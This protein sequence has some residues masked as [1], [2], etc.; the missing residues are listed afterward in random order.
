LDSATDRAPKVLLV[1]GIA[2]EQELESFSMTLTTAQLM[3][4]ERPRVEVGNLRV[5]RRDGA[6]DITAGSFVVNI[7]FEWVEQLKGF[8]AAS[9]SSSEGGV[10]TPSVPAPTD[11]KPFCAN[12]T[13]SNV[14]ISFAFKGINARHSGNLALPLAKIAVGYTPGWTADLSD[15]EVSVDNRL[16][17]RTT[18]ALQHRDALL[19]AEFE[20]FDLNIQ[21]L[22][23]RFAMDAMSYYRLFFPS[24][25][26]PEVLTEFHKTWDQIVEVRD[27]HVL[28]SEGARLLYRLQITNFLIQMCPFETRATGDRLVIDEHTTGDDFAPLIDAP[29][30]LADIYT[31][32]KVISWS[33]KGRIYLKLAEINWLYRFFVYPVGEQAEM[34]K[35][36][37]GIVTES[38]FQV[39][40]PDL[41]MDLLPPNDDFGVCRTDQLSFLSHFVNGA[42]TTT[43][44]FAATN[45]TTG[46]MGVFSKL[47]KWD[48]FQ[49]ILHSGTLSMKWIGCEMGFQYEFFMSVYR[50]LMDLITVQ[51]GDPNGPWRVSPYF[52]SIEFDKLNAT[53]IPRQMDSL[54]RGMCFLFDGFTV[55]TEGDPKIMHI[56]SPKLEV[57]SPSKQ[58]VMLFE[59]M[60]IPFEYG[61][62]D[63]A[64]IPDPDPAY[65]YVKKFITP[66]H[67]DRLFYAYARK[68]TAAYLD[69]FKSF[70]SQE[71]PVISDSPFVV[72]YDTIIDVGI[73]EIE[74]NDLDYICLCVLKDMHYRIYEQHDLTVRSIFVENHGIPFI[75]SGEANP[76]LVFSKTAAGMTTTITNLTVIFDYETV[77]RFI[78]AVWISPLLVFQIR[79]PPPDYEPDP[80]WETVYIIESSQWVFPVTPDIAG[81]RLLFSFDKFTC[82]LKL[83]QRLY[84][85]LNGR[86][87]WNNIPISCITMEQ[88]RYSEMVKGP[89]QGVDVFLGPL[90]VSLGS[91]DIALLSLIPEG[92]SSMSR[93]L[94]WESGPPTGEPITHTVYSANVRKISFALTR[95][96]CW[97]APEMTLL[98]ISLSQWQCMIDT[99]QS[100]N[101]PIALAF[102]SLVYMNQMT[103]LP[104]D[105]L[106]P[107]IVHVNLFFSEQGMKCRI[108][109][110]GEFNINI[111]FQALRH[112]MRF[113]GDVG[114]RMAKKAVD[115]PV[116]P[117]LAIVNETGLPA[118]FSL[119]NRQEDVP[120]MESWVTG[121]VLSSI[122]RDMPFYFRTSATS[123]QSVLLSNLE[124]P[125]FITDSIAVRLKRTTLGHGLVF[126]SLLKFR[127]RLDY[128]VFLVSATERK[129]LQII[130]RIPARSKAPFPWRERAD[131]KF[132]FVD[133]IAV[134]SPGKLSRTIK[135]FQIKMF[136][137]R[138]G[139][140]PC[141]GEDACENL[142]L[143][144]K[145]SQASYVL[146]L[147]IEPLIVAINRLP[148]PMG[149]T[150]SGRTHGLPVNEPVG[151]RRVKAAGTFRAH[152][153]LQGWTYGTT[154]VSISTE[155]EATS[156]LV[157][158][159]ELTIACDAVRKDEFSQI[160]LIFYAPVILFN[161]SSQVFYVYTGPKDR[162]CEFVP[163]LSGADQNNDGILLLGKRSYFS[164]TPSLPIQLLVPADPNSTVPN[165]NELYSFS[166]WI[167]CVSLDTHKPFLI[168]HP[169]MR[170]TFVPLHYTI[171]S[172]QPYARSI[173]VTV[174]SQYSVT[175][176]LGYP[177]TIQP[178]R[179]KYKG[180]AI[181]LQVRVLPNQ[182]AR[183]L[184]ASA[185]MCFGFWSD[186]SPH[187]V[188]LE[189]VQ[190]VRRTFLVKTVTDEPAFI[191]YCLEERGLDIAVTFKRANF[192][193]P[194]MICNVFDVD[195]QYSQ[196]PSPYRVLVPARSTRI[197]GWE[198]PAAVTFITVHI[199]GGEIRICADLTKEKTQQVGDQTVHVFFRTMGRFQLVFISP[200]P[201]EAAPET[202]FSLKLV[203]PNI[204]VALIDDKVREFLLFSM[205]H[206]GA[207]FWRNASLSALSVFVHAV[208]LDDLHPQ[209]YYRVPMIGDPCGNCHFVEFRCSMYSNTALFT[210]FRDISFR[211]QQLLFF[212]DIRFLSDL[213]NFVHPHLS[214]T[215]EI[216]PPD[217]S[218]S[219]STLANLP[220][221]VDALIIYPASILISSRTS[222]GRPNSSPLFYS[223]MRFVPNITGFELK[224]PEKIARD[225]TSINA[226][227]LQKEI[228]DGY[229]SA[230]RDQLW[231]VI[232]NIDLLGRKSMTNTAVKQELAAGVEDAGLTAM[233]RR[234][235]R[236]MPRRQILRFDHLLSIWQSLIQGDRNSKHSY[237]GET[238]ELWVRHKQS[239]RAFCF[240]QRYCFEIL[241]Q[242]AG[243]SLQLG[244]IEKLKFAAKVEQCVQESTNNEPPILEV[245]IAGR[246]PK[247]DLRIICPDFLTAE[248]VKSYIESRYRALNFGS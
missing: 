213:L 178:L 135:T 167:E 146:T 102:T 221:S 92:F 131:K 177:I 86:A 132:A 196:H 24:P 173:V 13:L 204:T 48:S 143:T 17:S 110:I 179:G 223:K 14:S 202:T 232:G 190:H 38:V 78:T 91:I 164:A 109:V 212:I 245:V 115:E 118:Q 185:E 45:V 12:I 246:P 134:Q 222:T 180:I 107:L 214:G 76:A 3:K 207:S 50:Y 61:L 119:R 242:H 40:L 175:N 153:M 227:S 2:V 181:G 87:A 33:P 105:I 9:A 243:R 193:Q 43:I 53:V 186:I 97:S 176:E 192:A 231:T 248:H 230:F 152:I 174:F 57:T 6:Q 159:R 99:A 22:D 184:S 82:R 29:G 237:P 172:F 95:G 140:A 21:S 77:G 65:L 120:S 96:Y 220:V 1:S 168:A 59:G 4:G 31:G 34:L 206:I 149:L 55:R 194:I 28:V 147:T 148:F 68:T 32:R 5:V 37:R 205:H 197:F 154:A 11:S 70:F 215:G 219:S 225:L 35:Y 93:W 36:E 187:I 27:L 244:A 121:E 66:V 73:V 142:L 199:L 39:T 124:F 23:Y 46:H 74:W 104:D 111:S 19:R 238:I 156:E 160:Q 137:K 208:Q 122:P 145:A 165:P 16:I 189:F 42:S 170:E 128:D 44:D 203:I 201:P 126:S 25:P 100:V 58:L 7:S 226:M 94:W 211:I 83:G 198:Q 195:I 98:R 127:S 84:D 103:G 218:L 71:Q 10:E 191:E 117:T 216:S 157:L 75:Y 224:M 47:M 217:T 69:I 116:Q 183:I 158:S 15:L 123:F 113:V 108:T 81:R 130:M 54:L 171:H 64:L 133:Y 30:L 229:S 235:A 161:R 129:S 241:N 236:A 182:T 63:P 60:D 67:I 188:P 89:T 49:M 85:I 228:V 169:S 52:F 166:E 101:D 210:K 200:T 20:R 18:V 162:L 72:K 234:I 79:P 88:F 51:K 106:E 41:T 141:L 8:F 155:P 112:I 239:N 80:N 138:A 136:R 151:L 233:P 150:V 163:R 209:A 247:G 114:D 26:L 139:I 90:T 62:L 240:T 144:P 125:F 56:R